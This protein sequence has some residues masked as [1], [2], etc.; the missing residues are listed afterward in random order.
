VQH[1]ILMELDT[2]GTRDP[3]LA[4]KLVKDHLEPIR[5]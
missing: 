5:G 2:S 4:E 3:A 1:R